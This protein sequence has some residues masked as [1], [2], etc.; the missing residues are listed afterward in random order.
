MDGSPSDGAASGPRTHTS[1]VAGRRTQGVGACEQ[2]GAQGAEEGRP[3]EDSEKDSQ[4]EARK[5][6]RTKEG[7]QEEGRTKEAGKEE[8]REEDGQEGCAPSG[9]KVHQEASEEGQAPEVANRS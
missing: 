9:K 2:A 3:E 6:S 5:E 8:G 4:E 7:D 1:L